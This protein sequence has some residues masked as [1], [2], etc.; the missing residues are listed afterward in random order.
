MFLIIVRWT[1]NISR[2]N[3]GN[4][5][6]PSYYYKKHLHCDTSIQPGDVVCSSY[7]YKKHLQCDTSIQPGDVICPSHTTSPG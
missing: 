7:Y 1:Y 3:G 5:V 2:L 6:C 4:V